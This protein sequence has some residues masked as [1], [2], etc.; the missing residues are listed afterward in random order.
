[1]ENDDRWEELVNFADIKKGG[2]NIDEFLK[3][4]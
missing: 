2:V 4:F 1:V 3:F